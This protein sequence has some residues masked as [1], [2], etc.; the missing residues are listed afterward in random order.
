MRARLDVP[1]RL[2]LVVRG[3]G[4]DPPGVARAVG[5]PVLAAMGDQR[6]LDEMVDLGAGPVRSRRHVLGRTAERVLDRLR[7]PA[8]ERAA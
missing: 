1:D 8:Q 7:A 3:H 2:W 5:A 4:I 6:G